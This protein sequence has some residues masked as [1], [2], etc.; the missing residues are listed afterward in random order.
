MT[1]RTLN[2][3]AMAAAA[4]LCASA[5]RDAMAQHT[6]DMSG[7][8]A[9]HPDVRGQNLPNLGAGTVYDQK[10]L[11][12]TNGSS[13]RGPAPGLFAETYDWKDRTGYGVDQAGAPSTP[14]LDYLRYA[15]DNNADLFITV[16]TRGTGTGYSSS[17]FSYTDTTGTSLPLM[18]AD[19]VRYT[20]FIAPGYKQGDSLSAGDAAIVNSLQW[21]SYDR[22][23]GTSEAPTTKVKYWEIG[24]EPDV[25]FGNL[26]FTLTPTQYADRYVAI[27]T[28]MRAVDPTIKVGPVVVRG[29][30]NQGPNAG[31]TDPYLLAVLDRSDAQVDFISYHPYMG[32]FSDYLLNNGPTPTVSDTEADLRYI[33]PKQQ[34]EYQLI[35]NAIQKN[36]DNNSFLGVPIPALGPQRNLDT[37]VVASEWNPS[38]WQ[39][40]GSYLGRTMAQ[41]LGSVETVFNFAQ[42]QNMIAAQNWVWP[43][44]STGAEIPVYKA[45]QGLRDHMGD[46]LVDVLTTDDSSN[47]RL[48]TTKNSITGEIVLWGLNFSDDISQALQLSLDNLAPGQNYT[49]TL[50][51]LAQL[52]GD[53]GLLSYTTPLTNVPQSIDWKSTDLTGQI[54]LSNFSL[55]LD[56]ATLT[57][58]VLTPVPVPEPAGGLLVMSIAGV[59]ICRRRRSN[60]LTSLLK[61]EKHA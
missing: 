16:N 44:W 11:D 5:S 23:R 13:I 24:N 53:T 47:I 22:L 60:H 45:F 39:V 7:G 34:S 59:A 48:Y 43:V 4:A 17:T 58:L 33:R 40:G 10:T 6:I 57:A 15:R 8:Q 14:T 37:S 19:W 26:N 20:N 51:K 36:N 41:A 46:T 52:S 27:T 32:M 35:R 18:A 42:N 9:I 30:V 49:I 61:G 3:L 29:V 21:G 1:A 2:I 28:A 56:D 50:M 25:A 38:P 12:L 54:D 31:Q 55:T